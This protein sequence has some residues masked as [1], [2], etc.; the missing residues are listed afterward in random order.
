MSIFVTRFFCSYMIYASG[1]ETLSMCVCVCFT[2]PLC[3]ET[4]DSA[5][6]SSTLDSHQTP[7]VTGRWC[8]IMTQ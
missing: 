3:A 7:S 8:T 2:E 4:V 6:A 1:T 5:G